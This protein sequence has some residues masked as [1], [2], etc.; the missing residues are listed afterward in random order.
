MPPLIKQK[1]HLSAVVLVWLLLAALPRALAGGSE[2]V[3]VYN[4]LLPASKMVADH[5]AAVRQVP[6]AQVFGLPLSTNEEI[7]RVYFHDALQLPLADDLVA[8]K[9]W[10][11]A[12]VAAPTNGNHP[13]MTITKVVQSKIR[14]LVLCYGVPLKI[15]EDDKLHEIP[16][17]DMPTEFQQNQAAVDSELTTLPLIRMKLTLT[18]PLLNPFCNCTNPLAMTPTNGLLM[19]SRLDGPTPAVANGLVDKAIEAETHGFWGRAYFDARGL[20]ATNF[21]Y[22]GDTWILGAAELAHRLGFETNV[23]DI[24][25]TFPA[26][27][28]LSQVALYAGWYDTD[29][30]GPFAAPTVEFMPGAFAYHLHS[31]SAKTV[32]SLTLNWVG[33]LIGKGATCTM[34][35]VYEPYLMFT[36]N[37]AF[38]LEAWG[39]GFTF[40]EAAWAAQRALS[41]QTA[42]VGDPLYRPFGRDLLKQHNALL[43]KKSALADWSGLRLLDLEMTHG[44]PA[45]K[46]A[47]FLE[48][49]EQAQHSGVLLEKL[50]DL[51]LQLAKPAASIEVLQQA[52]KFATSPPQRLRLRLTLATRLQAAGRT[53]DL[54][55]DYH[56][57]LTEHPDYPGRPGIEEK[58][59]NLEVK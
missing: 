43:E 49:L 33:P 11:F 57:L 36:P 16:P 46:V 12:E 27:Y 52:L 45:A 17:M 15:A 44:L 2:V 56:A 26:G 39:N 47:A 31:Y 29:V 10:Q 13:P 22:P 23:D 25:E 34:G 6:A 38:F 37:V 41:W 32:R 3:V 55:A 1:L 51:D 14:Y 8:A 21:Y 59:K 58:L 40:G 28:P 48:H 50:A 54:I 19:V 30:S 20:P 24:P 7:S 9:L 35:C 4:S 5:Y 18:G 42:V 53:G